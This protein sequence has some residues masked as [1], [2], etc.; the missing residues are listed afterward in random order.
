MLIAQWLQLKLRITRLGLHPRPFWGFDFTAALYEVHTL[1][2]FPS[3]KNH[4]CDT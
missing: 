4:L 2:T 1:L 3:K